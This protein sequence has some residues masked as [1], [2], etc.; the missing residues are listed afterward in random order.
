MALTAGKLLRRSLTDH[1]F[2]Y[3]AGIVT[4]LATNGTEVLIPKF[5]QW[6]MDAAAGDPSRLPGLFIRPDRLQGLHAVVTGL[7]ATLLVAWLG[8]FGWRQLLARR[9]HVAGRDIKM[10]FWSVLRHQPLRMF[11]RYSL[12]DLMNRAT[13]DWN[14]SRAIHG[15]TIVMALD[16][17]FFTCLAV[18][19][20]F[21]I[22]VELTLY[23]LA[24]FPLLPTVIMRLAK[25]EHDQHAFAQE[26]LGDLSNH[27]AQALGTIRLQRA[28]ASDAPWQASLARE[29]REYANRRFEVVRTGWKIF[30]LGAFPT[31]IAYAVLLFWGVRKISTGDLT[32][33]EFVAL[34]SYVLMLQGPLFDMGDCIAEWQRGIASLG[35]IAEIFSLDPPKGDSRASQAA[36]H[37]GAIDVRHLSFAYPDGGREVLTDVS[38]AMGAGETVGIFGPIGAGKTTLLSLVSGL[39]EAPPARVTVGGHDAAE[40]ERTWFAEHVSMVPQRAF[41]FAGSIRYNLELDESFG[42]E[43]LWEIL[44]VVRL[45]GDVR[46]FPDGLD[47]WVGEWGINLSGG[48]K[49]RLALARAL[50]RRRDVLLLDDCLS[51]V[52]AVTE[53]SILANLKAR[54]GRS[55]VIWVAHRMSTLR[56]CDRIFSLDAGRLVDVGG[57]VE[58]LSAVAHAASL[59]VGREAI[60]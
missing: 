18:T 60:P 12:G 31:L 59:G 13:G 27:I 57:R 39:L 58:G 56:H 22:D 17:I 44:E 24:I 46:G 55:T 20:M 26:K 33:G 45:T 19:A 32:L 37:D 47:T 50:L 52:D 42:D 23:C 38:L 35:R 6:S 29:A 25:K 8:R 21:L 48:Q 28:T 51:A 54:L 30:P 9:T 2:A 41:L 49:Q 5:I 15:F 1:W 11:H 7:L 10:R 3:A 4:L 43:A 16:L 40:L 34:Q 53:E 14:A 36:G